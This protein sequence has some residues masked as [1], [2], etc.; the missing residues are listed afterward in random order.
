[1]R[2]FRYFWPYR[3]IWPHLRRTIAEAGVQ[4]VAVILQDKLEAGD[5]RA[6]AG[7]SA[8]VKGAR[9]LKPVIARLSRVKRWSTN[10]WKCSDA[11]QTA[12]ASH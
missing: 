2:A 6:E 7:L 10:G 12:E 8:Q 9:R 4:G 11:P 1:M 3:N 5:V